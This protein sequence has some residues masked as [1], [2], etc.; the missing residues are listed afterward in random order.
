MIRFLAAFKN[1]VVKPGCQIQ[2]VESYFH[3][4]QFQKLVYLGT[5]F[6]LRKDIWVGGPEKGNFFLE[7]KKLD[8]LGIMKSIINNIVAVRIHKNEC[9]SID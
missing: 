9:A 4:L 7:Y 8:I 3:D 2:V 6:I 1:S 5:N